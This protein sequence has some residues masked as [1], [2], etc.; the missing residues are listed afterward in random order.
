[1]K[2]LMRM[3]LGKHRELPKKA[4]F[5]FADGIRRCGDSVTIKYESNFKGDVSWLSDYDMVIAWGVRRLKPIHQADK[6]IL[7]LEKGYIGNRNEWVSLGYGGLSGQSR[8]IIGTEPRW[9]QLWGEDILKP[10]SMDYDHVLLVGQVANDMSVW[11][12]GGIHK[13][14]E[15][16]ADHYCSKGIPVA[17]RRHPLEAIPTPCPKNATMD[18][19]E[20]LQDAMKN[21]LV[22]TYS[23]NVGVDAVLAGRPTVAVNS[24]S[25]VYGWVGRKL[26]EVGSFDREPWLHRMAYCQWNLGEL[27]D[28]TAW[29]HYRTHYANRNVWETIRHR[30]SCRCFL[31]GPIPKGMLWRVLEAG[32]W[33]PSGSNSQNHRF[34]LIDDKHEIERLGEMKNPHK[35]V[36]N[37]AACIVVFS[38]NTAHTIHKERERI[39]WEGLW[40]QNCAAAIQNMLLAATD[41]GIGS[42]W[43]S[44]F[45]SMDGTRLLKNHTWRELFCDYDVPS[46]HSI[47]GLIL[48]GWPKR[49]VGGWPAGDESHGGK[50]VEGRTLNRFLIGKK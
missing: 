35:L 26:D 16:V 12:C 4:C 21:A 13:W 28:G 32:M 11:G 1:M 20:T 19:S 46:E 30:R 7:V 5:R 18:E 9:K 10:W 22:V 15:K 31:P 42:C 24:V 45:D 8:H 44:F 36:K 38:D 34:L 33:A 48:L 43:I 37:A 3:A 2:L 41:L 29:K 6:N 27:K 23:S 25:M 14:Y 50:S 49:K 47:Q 40:P 17:F 39:I